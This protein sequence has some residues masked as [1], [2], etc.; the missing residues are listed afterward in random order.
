ME[1]LTG[2]GIRM[3]WTDEEV[4]SGAGSYVVAQHPRS[5]LPFQ[6]SQLTRRSFCA[7]YGSMIFFYAMQTNNSKKKKN[8]N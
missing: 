6:V 4:R 3:G 8:R 1:K 2:I 7:M 5:S